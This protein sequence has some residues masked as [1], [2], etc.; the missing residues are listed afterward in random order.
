MSRRLYASIAAREEARN[1]RVREKRRLA[2]AAKYAEPLQQLSEA[3]LAYIAGIVDG[4]GTIIVG[5][6]SVLG[7]TPTYFLR[8]SV[9]MTHEGLI[10]WLASKLRPKDAPRRTS[11]GRQRPQRFTQPQK[12]T[13]TVHIE[14]ERALRLCERMLPYLIVKRSQAELAIRFPINGKNG[15]HGRLTDELNVERQRV[16]EAMTILNRRGAAA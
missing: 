5:F 4:E 16:R 1:T 13:H 3:E 15:Y 14:G 11:I 2:R 8:I 9:E 6:K 12:R 10:D 7:K